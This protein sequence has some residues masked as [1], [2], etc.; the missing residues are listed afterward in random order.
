MSDYKSKSDNALGQQVRSH[1]EKKGLLTPV[2]S[3]VNDEYEE[4]F[5]RIKSSMTDIL[6]TLGLDLS[7]DSLSE[8]PSRVAKMYLNDLFWGLD[9]NNFPK[10]TTVENKMSSP[11]EFV[12]VKD[13]ATCSTCE[14][15]LVVIDSNV[16]IAYVPRGR[17]LGLSK[18]ARVAEFFAA[19]P[20]VQERTTQQ[21]CE[22][23]KCILS[24]D[25]VIVHISGVHYCMKARGVKNFTAS[26]T[27]LAA[28]G[29]FKGKDS[30]LRQEFLSN[31]SK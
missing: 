24:T 4:K 21:I 19:V 11:E 6:E 12:L 14:H 27:T 17:V 31:L 2:T 13:I 1:L 15:H 7:D 8:T 25:D 3:Q 22:A 23:L 9:W 26:T 29:V 30:S 18:L 20:A 10:C 5:T 16:S 28:G